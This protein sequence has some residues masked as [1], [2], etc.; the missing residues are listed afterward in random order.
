VWATVS[1]Y[2][3]GSYIGFMPERGEKAVAAIYPE[4]TRAR[5]AEIKRRYDPENLYNQ[6]Q[7]IEPAA[8]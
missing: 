5:L 8:H 6:N 1:P 7:N 2:L 4:A 3:N